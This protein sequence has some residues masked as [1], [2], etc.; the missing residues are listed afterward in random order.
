MKKIYFLALALGAFSF[1]SYA[2]QELTDDF[3]SYTLDPISA[4][5]PHWRDWSGVDGGG[6]DGN[7]VDDEA[8]SGLQSVRITGNGLTDLILLVPSAPI[9]GVYT[10]QFQAFIPAGKSG[11]FNMQAALTPEG[12]EWVQALMG[13]NVYFNCDGSTPGLGGVTG[14][15]DCSA[16]NQQF[17]FPEDQWFK[18]DCVYDIDAQA[19]DMYIDDVQ[20]VFAEPFAFGAQVFIE[21]AGLDFYSASPNNDMFIDDVV[22]YKGTIGTEDFTANKFSV[23]PNPVK[24]MLNIK[25]TT[26]VD[27]VTV[28]DILGKVVLQE[29]PGKISP[30]INM[31]G[32]ASGSYL[33]KVTIGNSSK[34]V[35]VL[36]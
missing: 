15:I 26:A 21:L 11:Y 24:D 19:W 17:T 12:T 20:F 35:K 1:S 16:F 7:V 36:K 9:N 10:I 5:S 2:Q 23:Y 31:S 13:G 33:V 32:L 34:T 30:A 18:V 29:N 14:V 22:L 27:N 3:E 4:Q 8:N 28:Y 6:D 25:S